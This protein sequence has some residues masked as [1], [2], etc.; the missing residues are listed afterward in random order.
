MKHEVTTFHTKKALS[1]S[2]KRIMKKKPLSK[3]PESEIIAD[4]GMNRK[5]FYYHFDD[6]YALLK[7]TL[8]IEAIDIVKNI[9]LVV[10]YTDAIYFIMDYVEKNEYLL[11]C[12]YDSLGRDGLK[13]FF[14]EDS[15]EIVVNLVDMVERENELLL[16]EEYKA[17]VV[18]FFVEALSGILIHWIRNREDRHKE[19]IVEYISETMKGALDGIFHQAGKPEK[20]V[21]HTVEDELLCYHYENATILGEV[22]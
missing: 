15:N 22:L 13:T 18:D 3:I 8:E 11:N 16:D 1:E 9:N 14:H 2:L 21:V 4:C 20:E 19:K 12:A 7:W 10:D 5:T 17:F 6:I